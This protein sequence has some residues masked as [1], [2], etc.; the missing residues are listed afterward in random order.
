MDSLSPSVSRVGS[1]LSQGST[2]TA[3]T[4]VYGEDPQ[5]KVLELMI[6]EV[7]IVKNGV[8][9]SI[10]QISGVIS[11]YLGWASG[12]RRAVVSFKELQSKVDKWEGQ[13]NSESV[14]GTVR[15]YMDDFAP[16]DD[17]LEQVVSSYVD[18][19]KSIMLGT[20][21]LLA[22]I[23]NMVDRYIQRRNSAKG[24]LSKDFKKR[25]LAVIN[26][27]NQLVVAFNK[28]IK[29][30]HKAYL[31]CKT[32]RK[33]DQEYCAVTSKYRK[34]SEIKSFNGAKSRFNEMAK[35]QSF[36]QSEFEEV[37]ANTRRFVLVVNDFIASAQ[38]AHTLMAETIPLPRLLEFDIRKNVSSLESWQKEVR[39]LGSVSY[40]FGIQKTPRRG[41][42]SDSAPK[43]KSRAVK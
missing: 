31:E 38:R 28:A 7:D 42:S 15:Q 37:K 35:N 20:R 1:Q 13:Y 36:S 27:G 16:S 2:S 11:T 29:A 30:L 22:R 24:P 3:S 23:D 19:G 18:F 34:Y 25:T 43:K 39:L 9:T 21:E 5:M 8:D 17:R 10:G 26:Q 6:S 40:L 4:E 14:I 41:T 12:D 32:D 33:T